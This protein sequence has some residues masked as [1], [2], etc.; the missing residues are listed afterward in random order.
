MDIEPTKAPKE[1][2]NVCGS[3]PS[4]PRLRDGWPSKE[5][6]HPEI[7]GLTPIDGNSTSVISPLT[8][9]LRKKIDAVERAVGGFVPLEVLAISRAFFLFFLY[10]HDNAIQSGG[11]FI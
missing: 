10:C 5:T 11:L 2:I 8:S 1:F 6:L 9:P 7:G 3:P 4:R